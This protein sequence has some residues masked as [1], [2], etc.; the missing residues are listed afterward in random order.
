MGLIER[1]QN[2]IE[3]DSTTE[4]QAE[5]LFEAFYKLADNRE[6]KNDMGRRFK[7]LGLIHEIESNNQ[8]KSTIVPGFMTKIKSSTS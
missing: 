2:L 7:V 6:G 4:E 8:I 3:L 1:V 5:Q